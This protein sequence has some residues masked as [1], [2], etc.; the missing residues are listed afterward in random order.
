MMTLILK[1]EYP[2]SNMN[3]VCMIKETGESGGQGSELNQIN[4]FQLIGMSACLDLS[5]FF[6]KE[7]SKICFQIATISWDYSIFRN[8][9]VFCCLRTLLKEG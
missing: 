5:G 2:T 3:L 4:A 7:V 1:C 8:I 6:E 9:S